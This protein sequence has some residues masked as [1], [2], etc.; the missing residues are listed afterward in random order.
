MSW[1]AVTLY[2]P[3]ISPK[4]RLFIAVIIVLPLTIRCTMELHLVGFTP[5][6][7]LYAGFVMVAAILEWKH[8]NKPKEISLELVDGRLV[9]CNL[10]T[11]E[12]HTVYQSRTQ[13]I[14][15]E[16]EGIVFLSK[17]NFA[18][19]IPLRYFNQEQVE[20]IKMKISDWKIR[21]ITYAE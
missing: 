3:V 15:E 11:N 12:M 20:Q 10:Y 18:T 7:W 5:R 19:H 16:L 14:S 9:Y 4:T 2:K 13:Q 17:S 8:Y 1:K 6:F 21:P